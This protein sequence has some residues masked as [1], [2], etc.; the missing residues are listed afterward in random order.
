MSRCSI[1]PANAMRLSRGGSTTGFC[2][3]RSLA[4]GS[5]RGLASLFDLP[6]AWRLRDEADGV[7]LQHG[8]D[9]P[10]SLSY[11]YRDSNTRSYVWSSASN[12]T[13]GDRSQAAR[14]GTCAPTASRACLASP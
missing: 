10:P 2:H 13:A 11:R 14:T 1:G 6:Q 9:D 4:V 12:V 5:N 8:D 3:G 7:R